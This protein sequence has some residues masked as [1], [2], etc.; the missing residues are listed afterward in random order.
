MRTIYDLHCHSRASDG[1]LTPAELVAYA[2][3]QGVQVM[4]LTD[5]DTVAGL[6]EARAAA[7]ALGDIRVICGIE[8]SA[9]F[10]GELHILG[11]GVDPEASSLRQF[12]AD[13][14]VNRRE[15]NRRMC[16]LLRDMGCVIA[17]DDTL[18]DG[19][20]RTHMARDLVASGMAKNVKDA[21]D[22]YLV[23]GCPAYLPRYRGSSAECIR[24]IRDAG[25]VPV[26]A[27]PG[28]IPVTPP[29]LDRL[30]A[31]LADEGLMGMEVFYPDHTDE[32][33]AQWS[34]LCRE[35]GWVQTAGSDFH[36]ADR[37]TNPLLAAYDPSK[38]P[39]ETDRF[40]E[41]FLK[42]EAYGQA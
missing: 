36:G 30:L 37:P 32:Q 35:R 12:M 22:R 8:L 26:L 7:E 14:I 23:K 10:D 42:G 33:K 18:P 2:R 6:A 25:G 41:R 28:Q 19:Y 38:I 20:G 9:E 13:Q 1:L 34:Q 5:H 3:S 21:F 40:V 24:I 27:H 31:Q 29:E 16:A 4:A 11:Y 39:V 17:P 15:R